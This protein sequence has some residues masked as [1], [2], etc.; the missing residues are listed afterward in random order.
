MVIETLPVD[1]YNVTIAII[2]VGL[3]YLTIFS[4]ICI[5]R[6]IIVVSFQRN[7]RKQSI[8]YY[9]E[10]MVHVIMGWEKCTQGTRT[11]K[12]SVKYTR[13]SHGGK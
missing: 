7:V 4:S 5:P 11:R 12:G 3:T 9:C 8:T 10:G 1:E 13:L 6:N 2:E